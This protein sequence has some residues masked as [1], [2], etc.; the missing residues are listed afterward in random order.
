MKKSL[1]ALAALAAVTAASAQS[2]VTIGGG[3][4]LFV[5][6]STHNGTESGLQVGRQTGNIAFKGTEDLGG[7]LKAH[8][9][10]QQ[11]IGGAADTRVAGS[12]ATTLGNRGVYVAIDGGFGSVLI[13]RAA[14]AIRANFGAADVSRL[15]VPLGLSEASAAYSG[16]GTIPAVASGDAA[17]R[18]IYGDQ[19]SN[20]VAY[21]TPKISGFSASVGVAPVEGDTAT[22]KDTVS[23]GVN[24]ANGP[25]DVRVNMT[26]VAASSTDVGFKWTTL[27]ASY[28]VGFAKLGFAHQTTKVD[29]GVNP[30]AGTT[31]IANV[32]VGPGSIGL[33]Y[34]RK[35]ASAS[36]NLRAGGDDAKQMFVGY[37]YDLSKRTSVQAVYNKLS[38]TVAKATA[39]E[40]FLLVTHSF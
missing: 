9:E 28:D 31:V 24:Y 27:T 13:G 29:S 36:T 35:A 10:L 37:R 6:N 12:A 34:G 38:R 5:G 40:T 23:Y 3:L 16:N 17:A 7:G 21:S 33:G 18:I 32:P 11:N 14:S 26:D 39:K 25:L 8:F 15:G 4:A 2:T 19:Y 1:I 30:G 22:T 20:M